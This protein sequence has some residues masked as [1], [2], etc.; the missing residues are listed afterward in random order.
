MVIY[1][2]DLTN[3]ILVAHNNSGWIV[4]SLNLTG[5]VISKSISSVVTDQNNLLIST[6]LND[7]NSNNLTMI[8][9]DGNTTNHSFLGSESDGATKIAMAIAGGGTVI[10]STYYTSGVLVLY[11]KQVDSQT[12]N[13]VMLPQLIGFYSTNHI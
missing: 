3:N 11:E 13:S 2:D 10:V 12:W 7:G 8:S 4:D 5:E 6:F 9:W 1:R